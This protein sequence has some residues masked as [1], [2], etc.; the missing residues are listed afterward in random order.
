MRL[1]YKPVCAI[2]LI[3]LMTSCNSYKSAIYF[4][5][6]SRTTP[7]KE[8]IKNFSPITIQPEDILGISISSLNPESSAVFNF[9]S[10]SVSGTNE[11]YGGYLVDQKGEIQLPIIGNI[12]VANLTTSQIRDE[13]RLR[14]MPYLKEPVVITKLMNFKF[15]VLG[16]V[17]RPG[18][19]KVQSERLSIPEA[20]GLA[21]KPM[22]KGNILP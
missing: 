6:V 9:T 3:V 12:N 2:V 16:D 4:Q 19:F 5:D 17:G 1:L 15:S 14:L 18:L 8:S 21:G 20:L 11:N 13:I 10:N 22:G 7:S